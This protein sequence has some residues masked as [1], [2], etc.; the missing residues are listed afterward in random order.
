MFSNFSLGNVATFSLNSFS[1]PSHTL[2][3]FLSLSFIRLGSK[4]ELKASLASLG[5]KL[6]RWSIEMTLS[7]G[8]FLMS[9]GTVG[10]ENVVLML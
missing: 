6:G 9:T 5:S 7:G 2:A 8:P 10:S 4:A 3:D 1:A